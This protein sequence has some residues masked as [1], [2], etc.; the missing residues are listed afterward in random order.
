MGKQAKEKKRQDKVRKEE[1]E[2]ILSERGERCVFGESERD[3]R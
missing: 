3:E 2:K 1:R